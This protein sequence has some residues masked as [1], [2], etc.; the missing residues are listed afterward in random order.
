MCIYFFSF[1]CSLYQYI[2]FLGIIRYAPVRPAAL[3]TPAFDKMGKALQGID[4]DGDGGGRNPA[5]TSHARYKPI[6][7][8][9]TVKASLP[10][11]R[12]CSKARVL[13]SSSCG[14]F[15]LVGRSSNTKCNNGNKALSWISMTCCSSFRRQTRYSICSVA[16]P[17]RE[18]D[19]S[20]MLNVG[21]GRAVICKTDME[22]FG[23]NNGE[24]AA[25]PVHRATWSTGTML[26]VLLI[27]GTNPSWM[28]PLTMRQM[29]SSVLVT[30]GIC[31]NV[32]VFSPC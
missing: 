15:V 16:K 20:I 4:A 29:K 1:H 7:L 13:A 27:S 21:I 10:E 26:M 25:S 11:C 28:H 2:N 9:S 5:P 23:N 19:E 31:I 6:R 18:S 12:R 3:M 8:S 14:A 22:A 32:C 17:Y 24:T 30:A